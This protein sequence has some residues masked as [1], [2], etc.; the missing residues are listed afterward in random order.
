MCE[1]VAVETLAH[2]LGVDEAE[3]RDARARAVLDE[4]DA[5][6]A[7]E[8]LDGGLTHRVGNQADA[9]GERVDRGDHDHVPSTAD[10]LRQRRIDGPVDAH[11]VD[12]QHP[13]EA[14]RGHRVEGRHTRCDASVGDDHVEPAEAID[15]GG[16]RLLH[17][18]AI[19]HVAGEADRPGVVDLGGRLNCRIR[20]QIDDHHR[21]SARDER[22][23]GREA[24]SPRR[25]GHERDLAVQLV[26]FHVGELYAHRMRGSRPWRGAGPGGEQALAG[27]GALRSMATSPGRD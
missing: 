18:A 19:G 11:H 4:L 7:T 8:L 26:A 21:R 12:V 22:S 16:D 9:V 3:V 25:A 24:D 6:R 17:R 14:L 27:A 23:R 10:N 2:H 1:R 20:A 5:Q 15:G 13:L